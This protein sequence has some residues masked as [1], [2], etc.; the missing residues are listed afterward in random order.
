MIRKRVTRV[1]HL[2]IMVT[3]L[4]SAEV[5]GGQTDANVVRFT[6]DLLSAYDPSLDPT[7]R[8]V[9]RLS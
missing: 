7:H 6:S 1:H 3:S 5:A 8:D 9:L 2:M 4:P